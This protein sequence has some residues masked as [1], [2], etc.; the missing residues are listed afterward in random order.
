[1]ATGSDAEIVWVDDQRVLDAGV[2]AWTELPL[3]LP[4]S[5]HAGR[6]RTDTSKALAAGLAFRPVEETVVDTLAWDDTV[7]GDRPTLGY[8][9][10]QEILAAG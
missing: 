3:W 10:E 4:G 9:R 2:A 8:E 1:M 7:E 6:A 5:A